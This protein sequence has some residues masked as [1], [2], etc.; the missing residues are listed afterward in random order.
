MKVKKRQATRVMLHVPPLFLACPLYANYYTYLRTPS[1]SN[2]ID[3]H[4]PYASVCRSD[5]VF[6]TKKKNCVPYTKILMH[7]SSVAPTS[8][9]KLLQKQHR[10]S[11]RVLR[12]LVGCVYNTD[13]FII[14]GAH[15][16][17]VL[18]SHFRYYMSDVSAIYLKSR[19]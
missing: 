16:D 2:M 15:K 10:T 13:R 14:L 8:V 3:S 5:R 7:L 1:M 4:V 12:S 19:M 17:G 6:L 9:T 18:P 11:R